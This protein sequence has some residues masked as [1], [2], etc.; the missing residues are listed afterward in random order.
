MAEGGFVV[1]PIVCRLRKQAACYTENRIRPP[2]KRVWLANLLTA[3]Y[4]F[5]ENQE[6]RKRLR[7]RD[8]SAYRA[9]HGYRPIGLL[10]KLGVT[11]GST[12]K[13]LPLC[14]RCGKP[15]SPDDDVYEEVL[16]RHHGHRE[17][18]RLA[19]EQIQRQEAAVDDAERNWASKER[20]CPKCK[21]GFTSVQN[22]GACP[23][24]GYVFCASHPELGDAS[25][26]CEIE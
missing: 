17:C 3:K 6:I 4:L 22:R 23:A 11:N 16:L 7:L 9:D 15:V 21:T 25:W 14:E 5:G 8:L 19:D 13:D 12:M 1:P 2:N 26:W 24:C 10:T 20:E 18:A